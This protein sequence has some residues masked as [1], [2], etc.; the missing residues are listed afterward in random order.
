M[1]PTSIRRDAAL[2]LAAMLAAGAAPLPVHAEKIPPG[3]IC[4]LTTPA[5]T[6]FYYDTAESGGLD[7]M[8]ADAVAAQTATVK[9]FTDW[10]AV[11]GTRLVP[12]GKGCAFE[13]AICIPSGHEVTLDLNGFSIDR[14]LTTAI[15][16][17]EVIYVDEGATLNLTDTTAAAGGQGKVT[18][19]NSTNSAGGIHV[20]KG[21]KLNLWGGSITGNHTEANGGGIVLEGEGTSLYMTGGKIEKNS[22]VGSGG[23]IAMAEAS[24]EVVSGSILENTAG[25][26]G[27]GIFQQGG[28]VSFKAGAV[29]SNSA[30]AGG[31]ICT[32]AD[33]E[34]IL[35]GTV[36]IQ[37]NVAGN[38]NEQGR[39]GGIYAQSSK[40]IRFSDSVNV[41]SNRQS[42]GTVS[43]LTFF[44]SGQPFVGPR[45]LDDGVAT[46]AKVGVNFIG[47]E[48]REMGFAPSWSTP[49]FSA[50]GE[51]E[52][53]EADGV[54][55]L[56]RPAVP[57]DYILYVWIGI[58]AVI[59]ILI[60][61][62]T[63]ILVAVHKEKQRRKKRRKRRKTANRVQPAQ[64]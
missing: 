11:N 32:I 33:A 5:A 36:I 45:V 48:E 26:N 25:A 40:P 4:V 21:G 35:M 51:F 62:V 16:D 1:K 61:L 52:Y 38:A 13:G 63:I 12:D 57:E 10:K 8:W 15:D 18:G 39:G 28:S 53:I 22:A 6:T 46:S 31:G 59:V 19:G 47:G 42:D 17:G 24:L 3:A 29:T 44:V 64:K 20:A 41:T 14:T 30:V 23:G 43:N 58:G 2:F 34:L 56:K 54:Q 27:G 50:D 37:N 60:V 7:A 55:Y 49:V 9:L